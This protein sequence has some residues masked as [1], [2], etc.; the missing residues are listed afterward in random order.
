MKEQFRPRLSPG[1]MK[2]IEDYRN[3]LVRETENKN[4]ITD[5]CPI[6][7]VEILVGEEWGKTGVW[8]RRR[9]P[10]KDRRILVIGDLHA[11][12]TRKDYFAFCK[13]LEARYRT[14]H[15]IFIGDIIDNHYMS[16]WD[17]DPDGHGAGEELDRAID[18]L[19][20]WH[21]AF[22]NADVI[23]GNHD[24]R[25]FKQMFKAGIS[26]KWMRRFSDVL[27]TPSWNF[28]QS[29]EYDNV[30]YVHGGRG[31]AVSGAINRAIKRGKSVVQGHH[32]T[33][34]YVRYH[35]TDVSRIFGMQVGCGI[36]EDTY[37]ADYAKDMM[38]RFI[39]SAGV[40][41]DEGNLPIVELMRL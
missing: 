2:L 26:K 5:E 41:L 28:Q 33:A 9:L 35:V 21:E 19:T 12:F 22:P 24:I 40:V 17:T 32:H 16:F 38:S 11:P 34:S 10:D 27:R 37:A 39:I 18:E 23:L 20:K 1:E 25:I 3:G 4:L 15:T 8:S 29:V 6:T 31:G 14:N 7:G 13:E 30:T 36:D